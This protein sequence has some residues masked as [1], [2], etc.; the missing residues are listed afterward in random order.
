MKKVIIVDDE[1]NIRERMATFLPWDDFGYE[2]VGL[3][4]NGLQALELIER[5]APDMVLTDVKMN[6]M[7]GI[8]LAKIIHDQ[9][10]DIITVFVSSYDEFKYAQEA[11]KYR[12]RAYLLKPVMIKEFNE[13][14]TDLSPSINHVSS[15]LAESNNNE[16]GELSQYV[17]FAT[18]YI[19]EHYYEDLSVEDLANKLFIHKTYLSKLFNEEIG[20]GFNAYLNRVRINHALVMLKY[21]DKALKEISEEVGFNSHSYFNKVFKLHMEMSPLQYRK[22]KE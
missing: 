4:D 1:R 14:M 11:L 16:T 21:T 12:V 3:A 8:E 6:Q 10:P 7:N 19:E 15:E 22:S 18:E 2:V 5:F 9:Y 13:L 20:E 17:K